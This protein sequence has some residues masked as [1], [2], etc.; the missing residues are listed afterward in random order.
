MN[1]TAAYWNIVPVDIHAEEFSAGWPCPVCHAEAGEL[2]A[3]GDDNRAGQW[4][5]EPHQARVDAVPPVV[6]LA[7]DVVSAMPGYRVSLSITD[8]RL[9]IPV[10]SDL[11][12][13]FEQWGGQPCAPGRLRRLAQS[14]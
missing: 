13:L 6:W 3:E 12:E 7:W 4:S 9:L 5:G 10:T 11:A 8:R 2:C 14:R 1:T